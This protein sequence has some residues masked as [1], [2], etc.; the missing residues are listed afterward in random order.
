MMRRTA[1][2]GRGGRAFTRGG[3]N[4][5]HASGREGRG[6]AWVVARRGGWGEAVGSQ[7]ARG[8][9]TG[10]HG[11]HGGSIGG[12]KLRRVLDAGMRGRARTMV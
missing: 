6:V 4:R 12:G 8:C 10:V 9:A 3:A 7:L 1:R 2:K 11:D 5:T